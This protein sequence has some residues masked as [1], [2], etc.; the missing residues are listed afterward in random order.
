MTKEEINALLDFYSEKGRALPWREEVTP[1]HVYV[2]EIRL[3]QTRVEAVKDY[4]LRFRKAFPTR[5]DFADSEEDV[6]LKLWQGLGYYSRVKNRHK[7]RKLLADE[8]REIPDTPEELVKL[9]G[10]G[11]YTSKSI[12]SIAYQ[13]RAVSVDGNL[14]RIFS[15]LT[16]YKEPFSLS[17][18][19][20]CEAFFLPY[21]PLRSGDFNQALRDLGER[22]CLPKGTPLCSSCP[23]KNSCLAHLKSKETSFPVRKAKPKKKEE[24]HTLF[25]FIYDHKLILRKRKDKGLL[26]SLY[27]PL[28]R[29]ERSK[30]EE[31]AL[32]SFYHVQKENLIPLGT[33][34]H[35]FSHRIWKRDAYAALLKEKPCLESDRILA[36]EEEIES[37][38]PT[39]SAFAP[40]R[41]KIKA[42]F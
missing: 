3:Q 8:G 5:K 39:P 12:S 15:R 24:H 13:Y 18:K 11:D 1:Y 2:S 30:E 16:C 26:A 9:P 4:Y 10:I 23:F 36:G 35:I 6:Y 21:L 25:F 42:F 19:K 40:F 29:T 37:V 7:A 38:Y 33:Y 41:K 28:N 32:F 22:V 31:T 14:F 20:K 17:G 34:S 27:E